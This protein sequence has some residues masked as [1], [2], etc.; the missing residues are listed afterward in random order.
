MVGETTQATNFS[1]K[2]YNKLCRKC[3][4]KVFNAIDPAKGASAENFEAMKKALADLC[5]FCTKERDNL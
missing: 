5:P 4:R 2:L 3:K 1:M